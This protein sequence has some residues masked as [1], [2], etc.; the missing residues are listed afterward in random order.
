MENSKYSEDKRDWLINII[1]DIRKDVLQLLRAKSDGLDR[2]VYTKAEMTAITQEI[3]E[4][5]KMVSEKD[6][7]MN[8]FEELGDVLTNKQ[9]KIADGLIDKIR[10]EIIVM[11]KNIRNDFCTMEYIDEYPIIDRELKDI[12]LLISD[13]DRLVQTKV[14]G[15]Y[16][17]SKSGVKK[18]PY[19]SKYFKIDNNPNIE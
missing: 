6:S 15:Y 18:N 5:A 11:L 16:A 4:I 17:S 1:I 10:A 8:R 9:E 2:E 14:Q 13:K 19:I 7:F 12:E 3:K